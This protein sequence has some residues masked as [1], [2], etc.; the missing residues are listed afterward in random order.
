MV[1]VRSM[2]TKPWSGPA[3]FT[4][5]LAIWLAARYSAALRQVSQ[6]Q[7]REGWRP[8]REFCADVVELRRRGH[9]AQRLRL[10]REQLEFHRQ[11]Q[12]DKANQTK[13]NQIKPDETLPP[14][15]DEPH[16][17]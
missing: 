4:E 3:P 15:H 5:T 11:R 17:P 16:L 6:G 10:E 1:F 13:S 12:H 14:L 7:G 2:P 9:S 8:L